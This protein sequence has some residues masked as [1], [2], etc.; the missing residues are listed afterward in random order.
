MEIK[1]SGGV[2]IRIQF[3]EPVRAEVAA[4]S[5][6]PKFD[7]AAVPSPTPEFDLME[8]FESQLSPLLG[9]DRVFVDVTAYNSK[10]Y[11]VL[12]DV[13][14]PGKL[15]ITGRETVLDALQY[16]AGLVGPRDGAEIR[17]VRP[18]RNGKPARTYPVDLAGIIDRGETKTNYQIFPGDRLVVTRKQADS[19]ADQ[20]SEGRPTTNK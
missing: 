17:L 15:P 18:E 1:T 7:D 14:S 2:T 3:D 4:P 8:P 11:Y 16:A 12:G 6:M 9:G 20:S 5:S 19:K 10:N 13:G